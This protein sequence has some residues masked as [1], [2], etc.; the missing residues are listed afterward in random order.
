MIPGAR[1]AAQ[2]RGNAAAGAV[3]PLPAEF[4]DGVRDIYDR[5]F[6]ATLHDRW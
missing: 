4:T 2:A 3:A 1:S 5:F 6:R